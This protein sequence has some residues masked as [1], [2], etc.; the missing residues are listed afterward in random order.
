[1]NQIF[2][3]EDLLKEMEKETSKK[4][5]DKVQVR[6]RL[7]NQTLKTLR[8]LWAEKGGT[9]QDLGFFVDIAIQ[10]I[11]GTLSVSGGTDDRPM[12]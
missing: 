11:F 10:K 4:E 7:S 5:N 2:A 6:L 1:M 8:L 3:F 12:D 9:Q